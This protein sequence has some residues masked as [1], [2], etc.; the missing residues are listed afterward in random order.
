MCPDR[1][2]TRVF[3]Q[4][5]LAFVL[6]GSLVNPRARA[7]NRHYP[8]QTAK[9]PNSRFR[10]EA[11]SPDNAKAEKDGRPVA[12]QDDFVYTLYDSDSGAAIWKREQASDE[13]SPVQIYLH[14]KS[15]VVIWTGWQQ[16]VILEPKRGKAVLPTRLL[17]QF[18]EE[19]LKKYVHQ[20][21]AG[22]IWSFRSLW[23]FQTIRDRLYF[24]IRAHWGE[25]IVIDLAGHRVV[26]T[27][28]DRR[29]KELIA[30]IERL[31]RQQ[32]TYTLN[33]LA[34]I[35]AKP[36]EGLCKG[37]GR[38]DAFTVAW[39]AGCLNLRNTIPALRVI[40]SWSDVGTSG[41]SWDYELADGEI[42]PFERRTLDIRRAAQL[43][44]R[45]LGEVPQGHPA[46]S[47]WY[48]KGGS[49]MGEPV[50]L[51][52]LPSPR[53]DRV[54]LLKVGMKPLDVLKTVGAPDWVFSHSNTWEYDMDAAPPYTLRVRW[55]RARDGYT[56]QRI[57]ESATAVW[58]A[59]SERDEQLDW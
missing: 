59:G 21:T 11:R 48:V 37:I 45:R 20:T 38:G 56:V 44:L 30:Q 17:E 55:G 28:R 5:L 25:H 43:S 26:S 10:L 49:N 3:K 18:S 24:I 41:G 19:A 54:R 57:E 15:W 36:V 14:D 46:T 1:P 23:Y 16:L 51:G 12:W 29:P 40:E 52:P 42:N 22:P 33:K 8:D 13:G 2:S 32:V 53:A 6:L 27:A 35:E 50:Q 39:L 9:S 31:E 47:F 34:G 58:M 7:T 4:P